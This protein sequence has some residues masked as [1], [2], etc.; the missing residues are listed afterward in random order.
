[1]IASPWYVSVG[2]ALASLILFKQILPA[3]WAGNMFLQ[4]LSQTFA[5]MAWL[6]AGF[7]FLLA[8]LAALREFGQRPPANKRVIPPVTPA[9]ARPSPPSPPRDVVAEAHVPPPTIAKPT[10]P[11]KPQAWSLALIH[12]LEWKRFE[13]VCQQF[14]QLHG[15]KSE[16]T[17]LGPD[18]G[19]DIRLYQDDSGTA[20]S[21]VQ[22]KAWG[23]RY[24]GV[25]PVRE[26][27]GVMTH[28][29]I[30]QSILHDQRQVFRRRQAGSP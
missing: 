18:G 25:K 26:L 22:C 5:A 30:S 9:T 23:E 13:D 29:K 8:A 7:F 14:Y 17:P 3:I 12:S 28:E 16:T 2:F 11:S 20:T 19:I 6:P 10:V 21:I 27:L 24:V 4:T 1:L 15:I